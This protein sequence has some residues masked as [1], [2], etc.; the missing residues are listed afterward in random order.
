MVNDRR[1]KA[2]LTTQAL[3]KPLLGCGI[4]CVHKL[5]LKINGV[6]KYM[7]YIEVI[8]KE[9]MEERP[10]TLVSRIFLIYRWNSLSLFFAINLESQCHESCFQKQ[11]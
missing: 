3:M 1:Q 11:W 7:I 10:M 2:L 9:V 4:Y 6:L 8:A 5:E